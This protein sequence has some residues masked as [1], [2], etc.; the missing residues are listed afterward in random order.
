MPRAIFTVYI[1]D[2]SGVRIGIAR[3]QIPGIPPYRTQNAKI[4][5]SAAGTPS[6]VT[7]LAG[8]TIP[9]HIISIPPGANL[10]VDGEDSRVTPKA[11]DFTIGAH[12]LEFSKEGFA[13][14]T[15]PI[16]VAA[17]ELP[18]GSISFELGGMSQDTVELRSGTVVLGDV[19][20][21]SLTS[22][23]VRVDGKDQTLDR[24][25]LKKMILV[26]REV[27]QPA[28]TQPA[29]APGKQ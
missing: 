2:Q 3:L 6:G 1:S 14:G 22:V 23:V 7:L 9:L 15:T 18:G 13:P 19:I 25:Q 28:V 17:D 5:F 10:K 8:R 24:N 12:T 27:T 26:E 11:V 20:S 16:E 29:A 21:M 4:Q